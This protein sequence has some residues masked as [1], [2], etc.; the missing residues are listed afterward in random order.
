[1]FFQFQDGVSPFAPGVSGRFRDTYGLLDPGSET[2]FISEDLMHYLG[3]KGPERIL[4]IDNVESSGNPQTS[5]RVSFDV[6][7]RTSAGT[8]ESIRVPEAFGIPRINVN[9][10][11]IPEE[12]RNSRT[13]LIGLDIRISG[14]NA[15]E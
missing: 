3:L 7:S 2:S 11:Y 9:S 1:M 5:T 8:K 12:Q 10:H 14:G 13:H 15:E 6:S 4:R